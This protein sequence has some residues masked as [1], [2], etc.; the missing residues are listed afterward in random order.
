MSWANIRVFPLLLVS[1]A[2]QSE[3]LFRTILFVM[4]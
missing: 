4:S 3:K 1:M 2:V